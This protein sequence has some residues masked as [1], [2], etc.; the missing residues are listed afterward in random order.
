[1]MSKK[2]EEQEQ[3]ESVLSEEVLEALL[4]AYFS[5]YQP[6]APFTSQEVCDN[7]RETAALEPEVVTAY[8]WQRGF[9]TNV[10]DDRLVWVPKDHG[11]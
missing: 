7:L 1:M 9:Q 5:R 3:Q 2:N 4:D 10:E 8:L 11:C 6:A